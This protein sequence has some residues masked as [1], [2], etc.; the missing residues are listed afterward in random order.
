MN[1]SRVLEVTDYDDNWPS[2]FKLESGRLEK[3]F[4][5]AF[6]QAYHIGS[7][8]VP[9]LAAKPTIDIAIE[10]EGGTAIPD[11]YPR[12]ESLDYVCRGECLDAPIPGIEGRF[13]F[14]KY[15]GP[16]HLVHVHAYE[17]GH[18]DLREKI[19]L[20]DYL[21]ANE[22]AASQYGKLKKDLV[23]KFSM[24]NLAYMRGKDS[25]IQSLIVEAENWIDE[26]DT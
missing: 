15:D 19:I 8:S 14:V 21:R 9:G 3:V 22:D 11:F 7:T 17:T 1:A 16:K 20:R 25:A 26:R 5:S 4:N 23:K 13:Y 2:E 18:F 24:E 12:M 10:V 6:L